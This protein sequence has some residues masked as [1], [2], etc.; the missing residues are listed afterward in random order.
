MPTQMQ[1][2]RKATPVAFW[3]AVRAE[4]AECVL[5]G[6]LHGVEALDALAARAAEGA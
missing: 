6:D 3:D 5:S 1:E 2:G 4:R